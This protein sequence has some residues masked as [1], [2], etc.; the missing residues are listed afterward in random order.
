MRTQQR[1]VVVGAG[2]GGL[3]SALLLAHGGFDVT[4]VERAAG[5]G[6]KLR[7]G[8]VAGLAVDAGPTVFTMPWVFEAIFAEA[9]ATLADWLTLK[10]AAV[11][12]RHAW[13]PG[14]RL[15]LLA[16]PD[17]AAGAIAAFAGPAEA[18]GYRRFC[19]RARSVYETLAPAFIAAQRPSLPELVR[20]VGPTRLGDLWRITPFRSLWSAL[21][22]HF[23]D[24]RLRQLFGRYATYC[25]SSPFS[26]PA[27]LMLVAHVE[28]AGV[29]TVEGGM[30]R[31]AHALAT[32]A[33]SSGARFRYGEHVDEILVARGAAGG[34]RLASGERIEADAVVFNGDAAALG[35]GLLGLA[36]RR[37]AGP[38]R[39]ARRSLS[40][41]TWLMA[42][43]TAGFPL[44]RHTV[45]FSGDSP[46]EFR[47]LAG[48]RTPAD[49]TVYVC[50]QDRGAVDD[51]APRGPERLL[52]LVNAPPAGDVRD[53]ASWEVD[54]C[55]ER[56]LTRLAASGL[57]IRRSAGASLATTP[58]DFAARYP[59]AG[60]ALYG[61][62]SHGWMASFRRPASRSPIPG[63]YLAGGSVHPGPGLPMAAM[64]GR[65]AAQALMADRASMRLWSRAATPGGTSTASAMTAGTR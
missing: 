63:L 29:Y 30:E 19:A 39:P 4:V 37:G 35:A 54:A 41:V 34:V 6:G 32:L 53:A 47:D 18:D 24:P 51:G 11:L 23:R 15:D 58:S 44:S 9:G 27:T 36:A 21:G 12:A 65:L 52:C 22:D 5:P 56:V 3:A 57:T 2:V 38:A 16:N 28:Q 25:G 42:A 60:G 8:A 31:I 45:F 13:G 59:G 64:S 20:R 46:R 7:A 48:G 50:A 33:A 10:P 40:A 1:V 61:E 43:E 14:E 62:A 26:A 49:P 17:A 55:E